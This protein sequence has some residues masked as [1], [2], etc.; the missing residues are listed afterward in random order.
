MKR[1]KMSTRK[2]NSRFSIFSVDLKDDFY[3]D[4]WWDKIENGSYEPDTMNFLSQFID[5]DSDFID[6]GAANGAMSLIS[7]LLGAKLLAYEAIPGIYEV[8]KR[9]IEL[10]GFEK[11]ID[12]RNTAISNV[13]GIMT[14]SSKSDPNIL[15]SITF[16]GLQD[17]TTEI[18]VNSLKN[19]IEKFHTPSRNLVV[20]IDI[21]GAEWKL[22]KDQ[23]TI[24]SLKAHNAVVLLAIHPGFHRP[25]GVLPL[26]A[27]KVSKTMW[28]LHNAVEC[29]RIFKHI[30][31]KAKILRTNFDA[32]RSPKRVVALMF[33]GCHEFILDFR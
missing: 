8:A 25:F 1:E 21:E 19:A 11:N 28:H 15:S 16:S 13:D 24:G 7:A 14:L 23:R 3:G 30:D 27:T 10:N 2:I 22:L 5:N 9:N 33:G 4:S 29:F 20:K 31:S 6:V 12:L 17:K 32:V 18:Q 26:G